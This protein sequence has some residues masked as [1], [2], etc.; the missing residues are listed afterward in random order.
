MLPHCPPPITQLIL[1][2]TNNDGAARPAFEDI[3][4]ELDRTVKA[5]N[6]VNW[7]WHIPGA[8]TP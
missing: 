6:E 5:A 1:L 7:P 4:A 8:A 2:C 3:Q